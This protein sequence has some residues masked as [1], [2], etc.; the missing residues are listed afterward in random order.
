MNSNSKLLEVNFYTNKQN[1]ENVLDFPTIINTLDR[2]TFGIID[3][4]GKRYKDIKRAYLHA[5]LVTLEEVLSRT[6]L[7]SPSAKDQIEYQI[8]LDSKT[9]REIKSNG[10]AKCLISFQQRT[11][12]NYALI[13]L[14]KD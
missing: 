8:Q 10:L 4:D 1:R 13:R 3:A 9:Y 5:R 12:G 7:K 14:F 6:I 2:D 11:T